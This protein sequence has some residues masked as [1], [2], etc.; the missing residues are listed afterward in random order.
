M[1][2]KVFEVVVKKFGVGGMG[3]FLGFGGGVGLLFGLFG[4][5]KKK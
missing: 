4:F 2:L 3:G 1:D 5:G